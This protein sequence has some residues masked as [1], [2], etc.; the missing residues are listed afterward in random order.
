MTG[1]VELIIQSRQTDERSSVARCVN[2]NYIFN[3]RPAGKV[4]YVCGLICLSSEG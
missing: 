4:L 3:K 2:L 1:G